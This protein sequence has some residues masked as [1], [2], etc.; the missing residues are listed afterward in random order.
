MSFPEYYNIY[1]FSDFSKLFQVFFLLFKLHYSSDLCVQNIFHILLFFSVTHFLG[2]FRF[3]NI[4]LFPLHI[5]ITKFTKLVIFLSTIFLLFLLASLKI[6]NFH[7]FFKFYFLL[8]FW[9]YILLHFYKII[10]QWFRF[11]ASSVKYF[12][13]FE[14]DA[15]NVTGLRVVCLTLV[16]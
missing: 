13:F 6:V 3:K 9:L 4:L 5:F 2:V 15:S 11:L 16:I 7:L 8:N 14:A 10:L 1:I 12:V